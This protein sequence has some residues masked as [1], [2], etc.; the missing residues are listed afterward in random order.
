MFW[1]IICSVGMCCFGFQIG[2]NA[3]N[4]KGRKE[5]FALGESRCYDRAKYKYHMNLRKSATVLVKPSVRE[6]SVD[7]TVWMG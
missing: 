2:F 5:G 3:G 7:T 4:K 6:N 1:T